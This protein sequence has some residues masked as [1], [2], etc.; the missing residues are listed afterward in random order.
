M[1]IWHVEVDGILEQSV[2][3]K[4]GLTGAGPKHKTIGYYL[5]TDPDPVAM[6]IRVELFV[7]KPCR[8]NTHVA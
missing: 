3:F 4:I 2:V 7:H 5:K 1:P 8:Q 6:V